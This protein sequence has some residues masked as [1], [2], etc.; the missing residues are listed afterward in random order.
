M[1]QHNI[2]QDHSTALLALGKTRFTAARHCTD[3]EYTH[4]IMH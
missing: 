3:N 1:P 2:A 4:Y